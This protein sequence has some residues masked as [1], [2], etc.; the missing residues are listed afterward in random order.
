MSGTIDCGLHTLKSHLN[1]EVGNIPVGN[2]QPVV[3]EQTNYKS[4]DVHRIRMCQY[5]AHNGDGEEQGRTRYLW[6]GIPRLK[7]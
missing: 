6:I 1:A 5:S 7:P 4:K 2:I 3:A